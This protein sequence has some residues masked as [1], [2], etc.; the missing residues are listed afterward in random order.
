MRPPLSVSPF[1]RPP[2]PPPLTSLHL[3][4]KHAAILHHS[5][6]DSFLVDVGS[7][8]G[9][10]VNGVRMLP[11][12]PVKLRRGSL[13]RFGGAAA[14]L[15]VFKS[16][17]SP[18]KLLADIENLTR[19]ETQVSSPCPE[20]DTSAGHVKVVCGDSGVVC[21]SCSEKGDISREEALLASVTLVNTLRNAVGDGIHRADASAPDVASAPAAGSRQL[22]VD[23][24][25]G[26]TVGMMDVEGGCASGGCG[27]ACSAPDSSFLSGMMELD[28]VSG[29]DHVRRHRSASEHVGSHVGSRAHKRSFDEILPPPPP[30]GVVSNTS[31]ISPSKKI[32]KKPVRSVRFTEEK[33]AVFF[34][35]TITPEESSDSSGSEEE[36]AGDAETPPP[37]PPLTDEN[38]SDG[39]GS[40]EEAK[41]CVAAKVAA[42][43]R[44]AAA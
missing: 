10:F 4:S 11:S 30:P 39:G 29:L 31:S 6:G 5:S 42:T 24:E 19:Q 18:A 37:S 23:S 34:A 14:P 41:G 21:I 9:T 16:Y 17:E 32:R 2:P 26:Q 13:L 22:S 28:H 40:V 36:G 20:G 3:L 35:S 8:H 15:F 12:I 38:S 33:P 27:L 25:G 7:A 1:P 44:A 43:A